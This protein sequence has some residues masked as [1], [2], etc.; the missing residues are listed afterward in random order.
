MLDLYGFMALQGFNVQ[1]SKYL[2]S[3]RQ[4]QAWG[5]PLRSR[6]HQK[7]H[8]DPTRTFSEICGATTME[9]DW[10]GRPKSSILFFGKSYPSS[11]LS[12]QVTNG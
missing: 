1:N 5:R 4:N 9:R 2:T 3:P 8:F 10:A 11:G 7:V 6:L 12:M